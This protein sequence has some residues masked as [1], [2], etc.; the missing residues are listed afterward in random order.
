[1]TTH[2]NI[3]AHVPPELVVDYDPVSGPEVNAFPPS[4]LDGGL[5]EQYR[6]FYTPF[7]VG[8]WVFTRYE[9]IRAI[10]EDPELFVQEGTLPG[11]E[12]TF[13]ASMIPLTFNPPEHR[14]WRKVLQPMFTPKRLRSLEG[15][16]RQTAMERIREIGPAGRCDL[17]TDFSIALPAATFCG[18]LGLPQ[19]D[20]RSFNQ[21]AFDMVYTPDRVRKEQ[22][23]EAAMAFRAARSQEIAGLVSGLIEKRRV[24]PGSDVVSFLLSAVYEDRPLTDAEIVNITH[25]LFFAGT[26][27]T[28]AM[29][30]YSLMFLASHPEHKQHLLNSP[31][32][33]PQAAEELIRYN[34][35]HHITR[36]VSRDTEFAGVHLKRGDRVMLPNGSANHD[37]R[38]YPMGD[39]VDFDRQPRGAVTFGAGPHRCIGSP[40]ATLQV[41]V[42]LEEFLERLPDYAIAPD[43]TVEYA[44]M[45]NKSI[46]SRVPIVYAPR[47][48]G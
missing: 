41:K 5:R 36:D 39:T 28:G 20:F 35:F 2:V 25:L 32:I 9:D 38:V 1:M 47:T 14:S 44:C 37:S 26:D 3:P 24:E 31:E 15:I 48:V 33:I 18:L 22:G 43:E 13:A 17:P 27:S 7:G 21:L 19:S 30:T 11:I 42:A 29:I 45:T 46:P 34:A 8:H 4:A 23:D 16:I 6:V 40:L 12:G 10:Y